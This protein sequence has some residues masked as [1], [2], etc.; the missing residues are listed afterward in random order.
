MDWSQWAYLCILAAAIVGGWGQHRLIAVMVLNLGATVTADSLWTVA[1]AD[2][3]CAV[4]LIGHGWR[5]NVVAGLFVAMIPVYLAGT[6]FQ[7]QP[8]TTYAIIDVLAYLQCGVV[9]RVDRGGARLVGW[10]RRAV[11]AV[12]G[13]AGRY[14]RGGAPV[15]VRRDPQ[16]NS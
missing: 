3:L 12:R 14:S 15:A 8:A 4:V 6:A 9:G 11:S 10:G 5:A 2:I 13:G 16:K 1:T 7:W